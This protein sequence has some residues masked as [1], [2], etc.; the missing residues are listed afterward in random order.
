MDSTNYIS[1]YLSSLKP[2]DIPQTDQTKKDVTLTDQTVA[3]PV[4]DADFLARFG[5][6][7]NIPLNQ[8]EQNLIGFANDIYNNQLPLATLSP[9]ISYYQNTL[10]TPYSASPYQNAVYEATKAGALQ[11]LTESQDQLARRFSNMGAGGANQLINQGGILTQKYLNDINQLLASLNLQGYNQYQTQQQGAAQGLASAAPTQMNLMSQVL[12]S[13]GTAGNVQTQ[14]ALTNQQLYQAA[15]DRA[16]QDYLN[17]QNQ[18][19][20]PY[21]AM[22]SLL[23]DQTVQPY[24]QQGILG[25]LLGAGSQLGSAAILAG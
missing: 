6:T 2:T 14:N 18:S 19:M 3:Q 21:Q 7:G 16:Y 24:Y 4:S 25:E 13:L 17:A 10:N 23:G 20:F 15:M 9:A 8:S 12:S 22:L 5:Y 11:N 1:D